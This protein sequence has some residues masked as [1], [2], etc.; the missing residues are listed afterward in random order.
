MDHSSS[1]FDPA[2][3]AAALLDAWRT[4]RQLEALAPQ[5]RPSSLAEGYDAQD[6]L[7][8]AAGEARAGWKLGVGSPA[9]LRA[10][11]LARPLVGQVTRPR[12]HADGA[13]IQLPDDAPVTVECEIAFILA[14]DIAPDAPQGPVEE[15]IE[16]A[17]V[18]FELVRSRFVDRR[19]VGWPSF[20]ADNVGFEALVVSEALAADRIRAINDSVE[21]L[22]DGEPAARAQ[23]GDAATDPLASLRALR[24]HARERGITLR[25]GEIVTTG[26]MCKPFD[27]R[28]AGHAVTARFLSRQ[29]SV[30]L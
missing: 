9:Q 4:G 19:V 2:A 30:R 25:K 15:A 28:G 3:C 12:C 29:L 23:Q 6:R 7:I 24:D 16:S 20:A 10:G 26:A 14:R 18:T 1:K 8:E 17:H 13:V 11:G 21:V 22:L 5:L 27:V